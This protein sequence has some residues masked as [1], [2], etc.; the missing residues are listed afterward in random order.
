MHTE[1]DGG[2]RYAVPYRNFKVQAAA[3]QIFA[4]SRVSLGF[5]NQRST[6]YNMNVADR[7]VEDCR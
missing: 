3:R 2:T 6:T 1:P 4:N 5:R 7:R